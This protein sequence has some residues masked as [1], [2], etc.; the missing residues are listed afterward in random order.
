MKN[1]IVV[2][3]SMLALTYFAVACGDDDDDEGGTACEKLSSLQEDAMNEFC[4]EDANK[5]CLVCTATTDGGDTTADAGTTETEACTDEET[6]QQAVDAW[7]DS[8]KD[9]FLTILK[10]SCVS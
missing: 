10:A 2:L 1:M 8:G 5:D 9:A 4:G 3:L 6:A 7:D